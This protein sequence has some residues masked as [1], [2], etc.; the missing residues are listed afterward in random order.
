MSYIM[1]LLDENYFI[2]E[3]SSNG[4]KILY[5]IKFGSQV[6]YRIIMNL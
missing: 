4:W 5:K 1:L 6:A 2:Y 3:T